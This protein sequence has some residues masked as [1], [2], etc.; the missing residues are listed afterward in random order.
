MTTTESYLIPALPSIRT[1]IAELR[2]QRCHEAASIMRDRIVNEVEN[3][4]DPE[5][6][7]YTRELQAEQGGHAGA[8]ALEIDPVCG[9]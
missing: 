5:G 4:L 6:A 3:W 1:R 2:H 7:A 9:F 8:L